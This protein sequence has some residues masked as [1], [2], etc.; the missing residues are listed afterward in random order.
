MSVDVSVIIPTYRREQDVV[1]AI[2]SV[3]AQEGVSVEVLV[4]DDTPEGTARAHVEALGDPRVRYTV[5]EVPSKGR[6]AVVRNEAVPLAVGRYL[7]FLDDDDTMIPGAY[8]AMVAALDA[9]PDKGIAVGIVVPFGDDPEW[10]AD[11][12][13]YFQRAARIGPKI[14]SKWRF[15]AQIM[16]RGT[17]M[18]NSACMIR[19]EL[20]APLGGFDPSIPVYE[21]V[22]FYMRAARA[23][24]HVYVARPVQNYRTGA[25]SLM[26]DLGKDDRLVKESY[27]IMHRKYKRAHGMLEYRALQV[28]GKLFPWPE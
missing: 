12:T 1:L 17:L 3:L 11:K 6:P 5:R 25:P 22:E 26:T 21:D 4:M 2:R 15:V 13:A 7:H 8:A 27:G 10:L 23:Y 28:M 14:R 24:G 9:A 16:F 20:F 18:V 19:R